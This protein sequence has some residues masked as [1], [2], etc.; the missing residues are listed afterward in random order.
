MFEVIFV[1]VS[2][3]FSYCIGTYVGF[4]AGLDWERKEN[5]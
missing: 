3:V 5:V 1:F 2:C 4:S